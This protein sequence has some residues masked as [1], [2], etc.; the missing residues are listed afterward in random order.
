MKNEVKDDWSLSPAINCSL[1]LGVAT[2]SNR[3]LS[4]VGKYFRT[5]RQTSDFLELSFIGN[6][7]ACQEK[8][9]RPARGRSYI[10][11]KDTAVLTSHRPGASY[12]CI[13]LGRQELTCYCQRVSTSKTCGRELCVTTAISTG[14]KSAILAFLAKRAVGDDYSLRNSFSLQVPAFAQ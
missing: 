2:S 9:I 11:S 4:T 10:R 6:H 12:G 1:Y 14:S 3:G 5:H 13:G 8:C 7:L